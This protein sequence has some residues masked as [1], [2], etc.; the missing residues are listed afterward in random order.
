MKHPSLLLCLSFIFILCPSLIQASI[1][2][3]SVVTV[4]SREHFVFGV[5]DLQRGIAVAKLSDQ[6]QSNGWTQLDIRTNSA[7]SDEIQTF[8]AGMAEGLISHYQTWQLYQN[9]VYDWNFTELA[10]QSSK[11]TWC[12][13]DNSSLLCNYAYPERIVE[14]LKRNLEWMREN[15]RRKKFEFKFWYHVDLLLAQFDGLV[16]GFMRMQE[17]DGRITENKRMD[18]FDLYVLQSAGDMYTLV[19]AFGSSQVHSRARAEAFNMGIPLEVFQSSAFNRKYKEDAPFTECS[20]LIKVTS[21]SPQKQC[22]D[23][24]VGHTTWRRFNIINKFFKSVTMSLKFAAAKTVTLSSSASFFSSKEDYYAMD[25]GIVALETSLS[26]YNSTLFKLIKPESLLCWVRSVVASRLAYTAKEWVDLFSLH[27]SGTYNNQWMALDMKKFTPGNCQLQPDTL[28][29]IEEIPGGANE[30][31]DVSS[32]VNSQGGYW[33]SYNIPYFPSIYNVLGYNEAKKKF[34]NDMDY[35]LCPRA[36]IFARE[37]GK[38]TSDWKSFG[39]MLQ[40]NEWQTD[41]F[42]EGDPG[43]S[44]AARYDLRTPQSGLKPSAFG[45]ADSKLTSFSNVINHP[46]PVT[47]GIAGPTHQNQP[48]FT[49][50]DPRWSSIPHLGQPETYNFG[51]VK[52]SSK[53][54][55]ARK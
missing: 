46:K 55:F 32:V 29:I 51:W 2:S 12:R 18:W 22:D 19:D 15:A 10:T 16:H 3:P 37:Q 25:S 5:D 45:G 42:S 33:P 38:I 47:F 54:D 35:H 52:L 24:F 13:N 9:Q 23:L 1:S 41:P 11:P 4:Y 43:K 36:K 6:V 39:A 28:W 7:H 20:A 31:A 53:D 27:S 30:K 40:F 26:T 49:W 14:F 50:K 34:G 21:T 17:L 48:A 44:I 8:A